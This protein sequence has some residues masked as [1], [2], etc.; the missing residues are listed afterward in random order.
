M[1]AITVPE[2]GATLRGSIQ[3]FEWDLGG[4]P[5]ERSWLYVGSTVGGSQYAA[6]A[7][8]ATTSTSVGELPTDGS[9]VNV[10]LWYRTGGAWRF[11]DEQYA[12]A[13]DPT[14]PFLSNPAPGARLDGPSQRFRWDFRDLAIDSSWLY[15]GSGPGGSDYAA[16]LTGTATEA[17]VDRLPT[18]R[19]VVHVRLYFKTAG[20]W[21]HVD[22]SFEAG[23]VPVPTR[24]ELTRELQTLVGA[25][26]DGVIGP[27]T[28][29]ALNENW[30]GRPESFD[31]SFA[32]RFVNDG[33]LVAWVKRRINTRGR[34][35]LDLDGTFDDSTE[36][37]VVAHLGRSG[38]VAAESYIVLLDPA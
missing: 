25:T 19:S 22:A 5:I 26:A 11:I 24:D 30:L 34:L 36:A 31:P 12:A 8:A 2:S 6:V 7:T 14:L 9:T 15:V 33:A 17:T 18:D 10:R 21:Y 3:V 23:S 37:A 38:V 13:D 29:A 32:A 1:R 28:R 4:I 35:N 20:V 16:V 27:R